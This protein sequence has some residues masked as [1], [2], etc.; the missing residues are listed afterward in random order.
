[1]ALTHPMVSITPMA[2][3][4][5]VALSASFL[6][7]CGNGGGPAAPTP[8]P[9]PAPSPSPTPAP[10]PA[11]PFS[12]ESDLKI[13]TF[14]KPSGKGMCIDDESL[15]GCPEKLLQNW[16]H[17]EE[18]VQYVRLFKAFRPE[19]SEE[20]TT[21][22]RESFVQYV[23]ANKI[24]V[25]V[26]SQITCNEEEDKK[27]WGYVQLMIKAL[28]KEHV[29]ALAVGNELDQAGYL[30]HLK[31]G[32]LDEAAAKQCAERIWG[33]DQ[34]AGHLFDKT[35]ER[36]QW[37][38]ETLGNPVL[39]VTSVVTA[40]VVW[41]QTE[42]THFQEEDWNPNLDG[43]WSHG[44][45]F[46]SYLNRVFNS[47]EKNFVFVMNVYP[48][49]DSTLLPDSGSDGTQCKE[50]MA[51]A[52][53]YDEGKCKINVNVFQAR[54]LMNKFFASKAAMGVKHAPLWIGE[55][56]WSAPR[57][58]TYGQGVMAKCDDFFSKNM[59]YSN[60]KNFLEWDLDLH[61]SEPVDPPDMVFYFTM[62]DS[63]NFGNQEHFGLVESCTTTSCKLTQ[64][65]TQP[66]V[67]STTLPASL[68]V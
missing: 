13:T 7:G 68:F 24:K 41:M 19:D 32:S 31:D 43:V 12:C 15:F 45:K 46:Q 6:T 60:Y 2:I 47:G 62:R 58:D 35:K 28:G 44:V 26:G 65:D 34:A 63:S 27:D 40:S 10:S 64:D 50:A 67:R 25:L 37:A 17:T 42:G 56:G 59:L 53:C 22:T 51:L 8:A 55:L 14:Q 3:A 66:H 39:P 18:P 49:F 23:K 54:T 21:R 9:T 38:R 33:K 52:N 61:S 20:V 29:L 57:P 11:Q 16:P 36:I 4:V 48:I 30:P 5:V 1:M